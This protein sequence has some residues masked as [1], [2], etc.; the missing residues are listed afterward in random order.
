GAH[1]LHVTDGAPA[2][3]RDAVQAGFATRESYAR[4]RRGEAE[5]ALSLAGVTPARL[6]C[7]AVPDQ[8]T[9]LRLI[10][11]T[12]ALLGILRETQPDVIV[13]HP[14]EGGHP[15]H[16]ATCFCVHAACRLLEQQ[17]RTAPRIMEMTS[18]HNRA[19]IMATSEFLPS[20]VVPTVTLELTDR[21]QAFKRRQFECFVTQSKVLR[22]FPVACE[23][24]R[25]APA[26]KFTEPPHPGRLYYEQFDWGMTGARWRSLAGRALDALEFESHLPACVLDRP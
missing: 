11:V 20:P 6:R 4:T 2:N 16:D 24:F 3:M 8:E 9:S 1:V 26:Y 19:G 7:L 13:T 18:Y 12:R 21:Q 17:L 14:Y 5:A 15:D 23:R 22:W 25:P 10:E